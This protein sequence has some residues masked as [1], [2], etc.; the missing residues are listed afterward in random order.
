[1]KKFLAILFAALMVISVSSGALAA[2]PE[3]CITEICH[4]KQELISMKKFLAITFAVMMVMSVSGAV[5]A[6]GATQNIF[7]AHRCIIAS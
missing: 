7:G 5:G 4:Q 2:E 3:Q 1:M 6:A